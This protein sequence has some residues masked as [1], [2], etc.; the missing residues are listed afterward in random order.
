MSHRDALK[1]AVLSD[2]V[3]D[4]LSALKR[5]PH[6]QC[7]GL[8][9]HQCLRRKAHDDRGFK[10]HAEAA[11][12]HRSLADALTV[13]AGRAHSNVFDGILGQFLSLDISEDNKLRDLH[14]ALLTSAFAGQGSHTDKLEEA[15]K[16]LDRKLHP[17]G[18]EL[19]RAL[20]ISIANLSSADKPLRD[21]S[22]ALSRSAD[23][24]QHAH[25]NQLLKEIKKLDLECYHKCT[26]LLRALMISTAEGI[27]DE[28]TAHALKHALAGRP[29]AKPYAHAHQLL[30]EIKKLDVRSFH[31][32]TGLFRALLMSTVNL[33]PDNHQLCSL[34]KAL[35]RSAEAGRHAHAHLLWEEIKKLDP[36]SQRES[37][38][39]LRTLISHTVEI[40][41]DD[42]MLGI[43]ENTLHENTATGSHG[44]A[45]TLL[46]DI[47][48]SCVSSY[49][50]YIDFLRKLIVSTAKSFSDNR[51]LG[52]L[53][54]ALDESADARRH[55][56]QTSYW[57]KSVS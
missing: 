19:F 17:G 16:N 54:V 1:E 36:E 56:D 50:Q 27:S 15:T 2:D 4:V 18:L 39:F 22:K 5:F 46:D 11:R 49:D 20:R 30:E 53:K 41:S 12:D 23:A 32:C 8:H 47:N 14:Q 33:F 51:S 26:S 6:D 37:T 29:G 28:R 52:A 55:V 25:A 44:N 40:S 24:G 38:G 34:Q 10:S 13:C 57:I 42:G 31:R 3:K 35:N 43:F 45:T 21:L 7:V 48:M 9:A